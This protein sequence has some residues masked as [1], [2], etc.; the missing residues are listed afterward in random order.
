MK[1]KRILGIDFGEKRI[2]IAMSDPTQMIASPLKTVERAIIEEVLASIMHDYGIE[3][4]VVGLPLHTNGTRGKRAEDVEAF[5]RRIEQNLKVTVVLWDERFS[6]QAAER[7]MHDMEEKP[8]RNKGKVD[9]I[10]AAIVLQSYL[11]S[12]IQ[13]SR[14]DRNF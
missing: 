4:V 6:T 13:T 3:M 5:A 7:A 1:E 12:R 10:A 14:N 11:D 8:S 9:R 2:G